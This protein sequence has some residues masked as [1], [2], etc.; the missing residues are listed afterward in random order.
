MN[1]E[2]RTWRADIGRN[3]EGDEAPMTFCL[4]HTI[5]VRELFQPYQKKKR[6]TQMR[7]K[8]MRIS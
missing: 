4:S 6:I 2:K 5:N 7:E 3:G 1:R 8:R